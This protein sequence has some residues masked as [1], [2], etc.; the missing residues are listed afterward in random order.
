[1]TEEYSCCFRVSLF[2]PSVDVVASEMKGNQIAIDQ[3]ACFTN[4]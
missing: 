1:M 3:A 4:I 2:G